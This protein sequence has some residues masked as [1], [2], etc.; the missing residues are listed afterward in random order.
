[1]I[2]HLPPKRTSVIAIAVEG[3]I[4]V[5]GLEFGA[6]SLRVVEVE[7]MEGVEC[8]STTSHEDG[9]QHHVTEI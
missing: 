9:K 6:E 8:Y 5:S 3:L 2:C 7:T 4:V 1:M